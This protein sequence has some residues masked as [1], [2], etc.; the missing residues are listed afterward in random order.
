MQL[1]EKLKKKQEMYH[2]MFFQ[3]VFVL[4][5]TCICYSV[6]QLQDEKEKLYSDSQ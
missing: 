1:N 5:G 3:M 2:I 4:F 6:L